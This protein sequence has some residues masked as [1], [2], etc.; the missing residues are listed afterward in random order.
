LLDIIALPA[1]QESLSTN[2]FPR[3]LHLST[4][5]CYAAAAAAAAAFLQFSFLLPPL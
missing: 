4:R 1:M 5:S 3:F 2:Y